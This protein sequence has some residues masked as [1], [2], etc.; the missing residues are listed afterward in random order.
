MVEAADDGAA[1]P[2]RA[3]VLNG[4]QLRDAPGQILQKRPGAIGASVIDDHDLVRDARQAQFQVQTLD[5]GT[6]QSSSS[7]AG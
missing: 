3:G 4:A 5:G 6:M 2:V 1:E 7:R